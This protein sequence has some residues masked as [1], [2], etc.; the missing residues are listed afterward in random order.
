MTQYTFE[1]ACRAEDAAETALQGHADSVATLKGYGITLRHC[2]IKPL[3][4][5]RH[6]DGRLSW[7]RSARTAVAEIMR[8]GGSHP[9]TAIASNP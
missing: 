2:G 3:I 1:D 4:E 6:K 7:Q 5:A 9:I 8:G